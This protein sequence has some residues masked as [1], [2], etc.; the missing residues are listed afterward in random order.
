MAESITELKN[1][2]QELETILAS[3]TRAN[4]RQIIVQSV[5]SLKS[6]VETLEAAKKAKDTAATN[7]PATESNTG[8]PVY[9][10]KLTSYGWD[11]SSKFVKI[12]VTVKNIEQ[13]N[14]EQLAFETTEDSMKLIV[15][16]HMDRNHTLHFL[17]LAYKIKP[18]ESTC[19][20]KAG[21]V[22]ITLRKAEDGKTWGSI[23]ASKRKEKEIQD[24]KMD[25][26]AD[27]SDPSAGIMN[28]MKKMY[29]DGDDDMKRM[30]KKTWYETQQK[31]GGA[32]GAA[33][34]MPG[35]P[36]MGGM[37]GM[38]GMP[39]GMGGM[40]GMPGMPDLGGMM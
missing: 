3:V 34:G 2:L 8:K 21:N 4:V 1:D 14:N 15:Q 40:A 25:S 13:V 37:P 36:G 9:N 32:G 30:I 12:Y 19:K 39:G 31:Q 11:E 24:N 16:N 29:D 20:V 7:K 18:S 35:M 17:N 6:K 33:G 10:V 22:V 38:P 26:N 5:S 28:M 23:T 27:T